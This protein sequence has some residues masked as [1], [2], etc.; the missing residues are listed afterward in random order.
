MLLWFGLELHQAAVEGGDLLDCKGKDR[1]LIAWYK[2]Q[3]SKT[4]V[5][6]HL[7][8]EVKSL[9]DLDAEEIVL[10]T[11]SKPRALPI[12][13]RDGCCYTCPFPPPC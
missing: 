8:T 1:D 2:R 5:A 7:N 9:E 3:L 11:G 4:D 10:A 12:P 13:G 6:V